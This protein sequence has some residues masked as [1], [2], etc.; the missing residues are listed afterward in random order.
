MNAQRYDTISFLSDYGTRDEFVG[1]VKS[2]IADLAPHARVIQ[3]VD[4]RFG[5]RA[6]CPH[7]TDDEAAKARKERKRQRVVETV[8]AFAGGKSAGLLTYKAVEEALE[9][10]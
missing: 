2:V 3:V 4:Q 5:K 9:G 6:T 8:E 7:D 10:K 1:I